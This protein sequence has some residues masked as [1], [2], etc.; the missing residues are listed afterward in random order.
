MACAQAMPAATPSP[1]KRDVKK[2]EK[3]FKH[4]SRDLADNKLDRAQEQFE[5]ASQLDPTR[6]QYKAALDL[7]RSHIVTNLV[8]ASEKHR[9]AGDTE[10]ANNELQQAHLLDPDNPTVKQLMSAVSQ[11]IVVSAAAPAPIAIIRGSSPVLYPRDE[12]HS[13]HLRGNPA[14]VIHDVL[15]AYGVTPII[16]DSVMNTTIRVDLDDVSYAEAAESLKLLS[17]TFFVPLDATHVVVAKDSKEKRAQY[18]RVLAE[19][20]RIPGSTPTD[21]NDLVTLIKALF[22]LRQIAVSADR[23]QITIRA[24]ETQ[25][26]RVN[27]TL[28]DLVS[29]KGQVLLEFRLYQIDLQRTTNI[30]IQLPTSESIFNVP[31]ELQGLIKQNQSL[32]NQFIAAGLVAPGDFAAIAALLVFNGLAGGSIL[33]QGFGVFGGGLTLT[34]YTLGQATANL[35]LN[36]SATHALDV[37]QLRV[38]DQDT[39]TLRSGTRFPVIT[40]TFSGIGA[41]SSLPP[42][43]AAALGQSGAGAIASNVAIAPPQIEYQDL[44][45]TLKATPRV[46]RDRIVH[47]ALDFK[48]Q[49][50]TGQSSNGIPVLASRQFTSNVSARDGD[51]IMLV[52][53]LSRQESRALSGIPGLSEIPGTNLSTNHNRVFDTTDLVLVMTPHIV[54]QAHHEMSAPMIPIEPHS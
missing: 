43:L 49:S 37:I 35:Q 25:L 52:S 10:A 39:A 42:I 5:S 7:A 28:A 14:S 9:A 41:S 38:A 34:G 22:D 47:I 4:G 36:Q 44:G 24:T 19:S 2:A 33:S 50:L 30:G 29:A 51:S 48:V 45:L 32:I 6:I 16:D 3:L 54:G 15:L 8:R 20:V 1:S 13:F 27:K 21:L 18:D 26:D 23:G 40:G 11:S 17:G 31:S 53:T 12:R 46:D